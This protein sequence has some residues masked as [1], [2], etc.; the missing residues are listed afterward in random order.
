MRTVVGN[1]YTIDQMLGEE[2]AYGIAANRYLTDVEELNDGNLR[3]HY[4][5]PNI[6]GRHCHFHFVVD[7]RTRKVI[8]WGFDYDK[9]DPTKEC[10]RS[11]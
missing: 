7:G 11:G 8:G 1:D 10:G 3:Y 5:R 9:S 4:A 2:P 6:W